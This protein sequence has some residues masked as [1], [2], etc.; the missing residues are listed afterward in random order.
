[1]HGDS[2]SNSQI[3]SGCSIGEASLTHHTV[4]S[5][6]QLA[7]RNPCHADK[8]SQAGLPP[9]SQPVFRR[10]LA[11]E[12]QM[13]A[14]WWPVIIHPAEKM[15]FIEKK[16]N[17][18]GDSAVCWYSFFFKKCFHDQIQ[19]LMLRYF[20][21]WWKFSKVKIPYATFKHMLF[22]VQTAHKDPK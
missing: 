15:S 3:Y 20:C 4:L 13:V 1:M 19:F 9:R 17:T 21:F 16:K 5:N 12:Q 18:C 11:P 2:Q 8:P 10:A 6:G 7:A 14:K 22:A